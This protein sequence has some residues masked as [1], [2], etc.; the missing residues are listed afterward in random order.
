MVEAVTTTAELLE[1]LRR[2]YIKPGQPLPGGVFVHEV[3]QNGSWGQGSR[4]DAIYVGFTSTSGRL[5]VGHELKVSRSDWLHE[6]ANLDKA[7]AWADQCHEWWLV[8]LPGV[9]HDHELP[10]GWGL[11]VPSTKT[12]TRMQVL[13]K[14]RRKPERFQ[15]S[16]DAVRSVIAR[17]DSLRA[18]EIEE[19]RRRIEKKVWED[20]EKL[21]NESVAR[22]L[23]DRGTDTEALER[24]RTEL[25]VYR[26]ALGP[27]HSETP[28]GWRPRGSHTAAEL[29]DVAR[30]LRAAGSVE[31][32]K[33]MIQGRYNGLD[34]TRKA[35][36]AL[37]VA[38]MALGAIPTGDQDQGVGQ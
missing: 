14:P 33:R 28:D 31:D 18:K 9:V 37:E 19:A 25:D 29:E 23:R 2:H 11:M 16:W 27:L 21:V 22:R 1:R 15:P 8:T 12:T 24:L 7:D 6:L 13:V 38:V 10:D 5:M 30:L 32:A 36:E 17:Q 26:K 20:H 4:C 34:N 35:L 3:G